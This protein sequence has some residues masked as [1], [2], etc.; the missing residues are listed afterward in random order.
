MQTTT[1]NHSMTE[2]SSVKSPIVARLKKR[3]HFGGVL[4]PIV[5]FLESLN[6]GVALTDKRAIGCQNQV[7]QANIK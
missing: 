2:L 4:L 1:D 3:C 6:L 5:C 7:Y